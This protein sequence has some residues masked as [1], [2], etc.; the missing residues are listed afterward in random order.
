MTSFAAGTRKAVSLNSPA[1]GWADYWQVAIDPTSIA[2]AAQGSFTVDVPGAKS[3]DMV[4]VSAEGPLHTELSV[5]GAKVTAPGVV[6]IYLN[7]DIDATTAIDDAS[8]NFNLMV[9]HLS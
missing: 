9:I 3:G 4:F 1:G 5:A 2:A 6:T 8:T 7:N